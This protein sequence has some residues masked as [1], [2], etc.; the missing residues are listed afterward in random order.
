MLGLAQTQIHLLL[1]AEMTSS[2]VQMLG[3][4]QLRLRKDFIHLMRH[5]P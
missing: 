4:G 2:M 5:V 1:D 3:Q